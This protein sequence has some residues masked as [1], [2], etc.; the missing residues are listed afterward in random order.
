MVPPRCQLRR[1]TSEDRSNLVA[2][3]PRSW[4]VSNMKRLPTKEL[5]RFVAVTGWSLCI[6]AFAQQPSSDL[7]NPQVA[8]A[9]S[10]GRID[11]G[12]D[13]RPILSDKCFACHGPDAVNNK[14][15]LRLDT[16]AHAFADLGKG[17]RAIVRGNATESHLVRRITA[18]KESLRMPPA[19]S[20]L[21]LTEQEI[22]RLTAWVAQG[23]PWQQHWA[24]IRPERPALPSVTAANWPRNPIDVFVLA[25]LEKEG[26]HPSAEADRA[27]LIR[28][29]SL[30]LTGLPATPQEVDEYIKDRSA[31]AYE[32]VV[33][34]LLASPRYG[35]R[36]A[37]RW[38]DAARYA[39][40]N[41]YQVDGEREM[42]RWRD[43]VID[44]FNRNVPFERFVVEQLAGDLLPN[45]TLDQRIATAF[46]RNHR[47][48]SE[49]GLVPE[50]YAVEYV[51]DR[52]DTVSTVFL[53]LTM[54]CT[55][56]H[57]HK[58]DPLTQ[59]E[60]YQLF[61]YFNSIPEDGRFS[62]F[63]NAAPWIPAPTPQQQ[64]QIQRI[65]TDV[66]LAQKELAASLQYASRRQGQW[67]TSLGASPARHW[68]PAD[69]LVVH[70]PFGQG[71]NLLVN[72]TSRPTQTQEHLGDE[73]RTPENVNVGFK[74]G[75]PRY[76]P[77][78]LGEAAAF[79]GQ[80]SFDAGKVANFD[81]RDRVHDFKHRFAISAWFYPESENSGAI[82]SRIGDEVTEVEN[83]LPKGR[84]YG[85]FFVN[86]KLHFNLVSVWAD[87]SFRVETESQQPL[88]QWHHVVAV[89]D[90]LEP[91]E[92]VSIY[93][94]GQKQALKINNGRLFRQFAN[95]GAH[96]RIGGGAG[97]AW[98]FRGSIDEVRIY[99]TLLTPEQISVLACPDSLSRI[100]AIP[101]EKRTDGQRLKI[102][103]AYLE[104][105]AP[106][107]ARRAWAKLRQLQRQRADLQ[108]EVPTLMVMQ[109]SPEPRPAYLLKRGAYDAPGE[110]V[111]RG[112]PAVLPPMQAGWPNNRL[113]FARWVVSPENPL[114]WRVTANRVWQML[115]GVGLVKTVDD[116]GAQGELPSHPELLDWLA[117]EFQRNGGD[118]KALLKTMVLSA[119][120]RQLSTVSPQLLQRDPENRL[121]ARGPRLRLPAEAI[122]DQALFASGL[123][124]EG[125]GGPSVRPYQPDGLYK[126]MVFSN[127][128][129]YA[130]E[131]SDGLWRRSLYTFWKRTV[132]PPA[133]QV[134]DASSREYCTVRE[135]RTNTPLQ[136]LNLM[137]DTTYV[138]AAR[139][140][141]QRMLT[142]GGAKP[143]DRLAL[144]LR[145]A[146]GRQPDA[147]EKRLLADSLHTQLQYFRSHPQEAAQLLGVG[148]KPYDTKLNPEELAAYSVVASLILNLDE[149]ISKQ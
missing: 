149:V 119:T 144:G 13:I 36:M 142:Q 88:R 48:N 140:M 47:G 11:F 147:A 58:Y 32:K 136:A 82:V 51:V 115:F 112:V 56:C 95:G 74:G 46:N 44:A 22:D 122:R 81:Y 65:D 131:K 68:F 97:P 73:G 2:A 117:V 55:R 59:K 10:S 90:S 29:V 93:V 49:D 61:A 124:V 12:R 129:N 75:V 106:P 128:T 148:A 53:G 98:L 21:K 108:L 134:F 83:N 96:L 20:G 118:M 15:K 143:E 139:M 127:M 100:A 120:Y 41:G 66:A 63:G 77:S 67:E 25:K 33:D 104:E 7:Q 42:W 145:L 85:L 18:D 16:E 84:G 102:R 130:Q 37:F 71:A 9:A 86:G 26:L 113:G 31:N 45:A 80:L 114:T 5:I 141:A 103:N 138:E 30:D 135:T 116:F 137:N 121:L 107:A 132:M 50:E 39:D 146:A 62:N 28:R 14:S 133:M 23:A 89:F 3:L 79:D 92:K 27:A 35:E 38:L 64:Q 60:Y 111:E 4:W 125:R 54:G 70:Q 126:D 57:N 123:L 17:R 69:D 72:E 94:N 52:V 76:A 6:G 40:T 34:R 24:F 19:Y 99:K 110:R 105:A 1:R 109:E 101:A 43:W 8:P 78:P 91:Y 87:D